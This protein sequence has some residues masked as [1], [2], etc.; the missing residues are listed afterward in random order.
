MKSIHKSVAAIIGCLLCCSLTMS[1]QE[2]A[3]FS[4]SGDTGPGFWDEISPT[5]AAT[6]TSR[7][8]PVDIR[9]VQVDRSLTPLD[10][11]LGETDFTLT[12]PGYTLV[13]TPKSAGTLVLN[14]TTFTLLQFHFH[15]LSEH[16]IKG[17]HLLME[18]HAVFQDASSNLAVIAVMYRL[19][20]ASAFL[21]KL[22]TAGLPQKSTSSPVTVTGLDLATAFT[23]LSSYYTYP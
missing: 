5:C 20:A 18:V 8:S 4:Y 22:L 11:V 21:D 6:P 13:A 23:D 2:T 1:A 12:N 15:T 10:T 17:T 7:Q 16:T 19:G 3:T 14:G 9:D